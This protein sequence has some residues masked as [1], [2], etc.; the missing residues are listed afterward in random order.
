[1]ED[2]TL[3]IEYVVDLARWRLQQELC[4]CLDPLLCVHV[5]WRINLKT[6]KQT[7]TRAE[8]RW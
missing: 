2:M 6:I 5:Q 1:M 8:E 7:V 4:G 3:A